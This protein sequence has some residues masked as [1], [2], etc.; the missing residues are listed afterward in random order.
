RPTV[1]A[2]ADAAA[3]VVAADAPVRVTTPRSRQMASAGMMGPKPAPGAS[4][5]TSAVSAAMRAL[6]VERDPAHARRLLAKYLSQYPKGSLAEEALAM[7]IEAAIA[8]RDPDVAGV[9]ARY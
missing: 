7:T 9:A 1:V 4:E 3:P 8:E 5:D 6:R 2:A